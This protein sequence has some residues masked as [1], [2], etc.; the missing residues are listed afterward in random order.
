MCAVT[1]IVSAVLETALDIPKNIGTEIVGTA[2][3]IF[4]IFAG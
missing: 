2:L 4:N 1:D 3:K